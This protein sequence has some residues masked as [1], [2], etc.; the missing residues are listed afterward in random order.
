[1][2]IKALNSVAGFSV[3]ENPTA[4]ILANGDITTG[5]ASFFGNLATQAILTDNYRYSNGVPLGIQKPAGG[6]LD[7]QFNRNNE[8]GGSNNLTFDP[9]SNI[10]QVGG[11]ILANKV[12]STGNMY[13]Q[14][15]IGNIIGNISGN[16]TVPGVNQ[17][18][19]F[20]NY[21]N[22]DGSTAFTFDNT[23]NSAVLTGNLSVGNLSDAN[24]VSGNYLQ[25][26]LLTNSQPNI[27]SLGQLIALNVSGNAN[28]NSLTSRGNID[29][30]TVNTTNLKVSV[31]TGNSLTAN[32]LTINGPLIGVDSS[33][34]GN[35]QV[36]SNITGNNLRAT[37]DIVGSSNLSIMN[38]ATI[39]GSL[40]VGNNLLTNK[41]NVSGNMIT[42]SLV[43]NTSITANGNIDG[44]SL[45]ISGL[46]NLNSLTLSS[47]FTGN[48]LPT[49]SNNYII[50]DNSHRWNKVWV[51]GNGVVIG[52]SVLAEDNNILSTANIKVTDTLITQSLQ[53]TGDTLSN[54]N[55]TV[56]GNLTVAGSTE[57]INV[58]TLSIKDP[59]IPIG[60]NDDGTD[61]SGFDGKD[62]GLLLQ[63]YKSD[64]SAPVNQFMGWKTANQEFALYSNVA[65]YTGEIVTPN[66]LGNIR[67]K[68]FKGNVQGTILSSNQPN[69]TSLGNLTSLNVNGDITTLSKVS[70][71]TLK[72]N[73]VTYPVVD[74]QPG[75]VITTNGSGSLYFAE[76]SVS[77][78]ANGTSNVSVENSANVTVSVAGT[79]N[80]IS[81]TDTLVQVA[82]DLTANNITSNANLR[83]GITNIGWSSITTQSVM[84]NQII[85]SVPSA[86]IRGVEFFVKAEE[87]SGIKYSV[88]TI[89]AVH[90]GSAVEY[91]N[92]G[93]VTIGGFTGTVGVRFNN[94]SLNLV[95]TPSTSNNMTWT[96]QYR[97]I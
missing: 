73:N 97:T 21:G 88:E 43:S 14:Y 17:S 64:G 25:G 15:F 16:L 28:V 46:A 52:G 53:T 87:I 80:V 83:L 38:N 26:T 71:G 8:F 58:T 55:L 20:N 6:N 54:G 95:V 50:G 92:Y 9:S 1:M 44:N 33:F 18:I 31:L 59:I 57:Y 24:L 40:T 35:M 78:L 74:G 47:G 79:Q 56:L 37:N 39:N 69:I 3:G 93:T 10:L 60:G 36:S 90:N 11:E 82:V 51:S 2:S 94:G 5:N 23:N 72:V 7:L 77:K 12:T 91:S 32:L 70:T 29:S 63:N 41:L 96:T 66:E 81:I 75:Y 4:I 86:G 13:A 27:T 61:A 42:Y 65:S 45:N 76:P 68:T 49:T 62:R 85:A 30:N 19:I 22:A 48:I 84:P 89:S 34:T 67:A